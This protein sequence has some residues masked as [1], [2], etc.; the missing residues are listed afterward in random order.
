[1]GNSGFYVLGII[2]NHSVAER[3]RQTDTLPQK[4]STADWTAAAHPVQNKVINL[5]KPCI[6]ASVKFSEIIGQQKAKDAVT[7]TIRAGRLPHALILKGPAGI[8]KLAFANAVAQYLNCENPSENDSCGHCPN[9][10]KIRKAIHP[11]VHFVLPII[12]KKSG[13]KSTTTDDFFGIFRGYFVNNPFFSL[14]QWG[15]VQQGENKQLGIHIQE[16]R[17][18]KRKVSLKA[19]EAKFKVVIIWN[20]EKINTEGAN[21]LLKLL[22]EPPERTILILTVTDPSQLLTTINSRCQRLQMHRVENEILASWLSEHQNLGMDQSRQLA[23]L[24]EGSVSR[25]LELVAESTRSY[26]DL[27]QKW[28]KACF[29]GNHESINSWAEL[30]SRESR[31]FQKL[32]L[33]F[34]LQKVRDMLLISFNANQLALTTPEEAALFGNMVR[35][36]KSGGV[37]ELTRL[38]EDGLFYISRNANSHMVLVVLS[39]RA[40]AIFSGKV[41]I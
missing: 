1:M 11:D 23:Q 33:S 19:F 32:F 13:E 17:D 24:S 35:N 27:F 14:A 6:F 22:E 37:A 39:Q 7:S 3:I 20:A 18:L 10:V 8:G 31:D 2:L 41:L 25:A 29:E 9:C 21:A 34:A 28:V 40:H 12:N 4:G 38:I 36:F 15:A 30:M 26:S 5:P 16:I